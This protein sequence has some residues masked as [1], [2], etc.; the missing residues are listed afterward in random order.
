MSLLTTSAV[1]VADVVNAVAAVTVLATV[2]G[3][4]V[5]IEVVLA[6]VVGAPVGIAAVVAIV[7][8]IAGP[9]RK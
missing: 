7:V 6:V 5:G 8:D 2:G 3:T 1:A 4:P 9:S